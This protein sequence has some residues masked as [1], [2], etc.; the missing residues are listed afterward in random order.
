M[1]YVIDDV[2]FARVIGHV[3]DVIDRDAELPHQVF[4]VPVY[5]F[6]M[7]DMDEVMTAAFF[8]RLQRLNSAIGDEMFFLTVLKPHPME[9][10]HARFGRYPSAR[11][12]NLD[13]GRTYVTA[14]HD[15]P[16]ESPA[17]AIAYNGRI[18]VFQPPSS[19]WVIYGDQDLELAVLAVAD[20]ATLEYVKATLP[21]D[22]LF[23]AAEAV[24]QL[25]PRYMEAV[26]RRQL[27]GH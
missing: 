21:T 25:L 19:R 12:T 8:E 13:S 20:D 6:R 17:D 7:I 4:S 15:G 1:K 26:C 16:K 2:E 5:A 23:S 18:V 24:D 27:A 22:R 10:F 14:L 3:D 9:Y 11:F